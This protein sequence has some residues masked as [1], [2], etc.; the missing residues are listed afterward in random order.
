MKRGLK[1]KVRALG[2]LQVTLIAGIMMLLGVLF[3][4]KMVG[5]QDRFEEGTKE[6][7]LREAEGLAK[8][9]ALEL[10]RLDALRT[11]RFSQNDPAAIQVRAVLWEKVT[12]IGALQDLDLIYR[13]QKN[14]CFR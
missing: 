12:F 3:F 9:L 4:N 13:P 1:A 10:G 11:A 6:V 2:V 8:L 5:D 7:K 14:E